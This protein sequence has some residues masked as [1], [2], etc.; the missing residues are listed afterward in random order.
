MGTGRVITNIICTLEQRDLRRLKTA[1][2][3]FM[4]GIAGYSLSGHRR[5]EDILEIKVGP[6]EKTQ[7][8][9]RHKWLNHVSRM[10]DIRHPRRLI[11]YRPIGRRRRR[12]G[13]PLKRLLYGY[14]YEAET[15]N[16]WA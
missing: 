3:K 15:G 16:L 6:L 8:Q 12:P 4:T 5:N 13:R 1:E 2:M 11:D 7:V 9:Y 10:E 14:N